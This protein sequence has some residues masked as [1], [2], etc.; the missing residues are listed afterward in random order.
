MSYNKAW[1][2]SKTMWAAVI[3]AISSSVFPEAKEMIQGNT[4]SVMAAIGFLFGLLRI[5]T[6]APVALKDK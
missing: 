1:Y 5:K 4:E 6:D 2:K 3:V